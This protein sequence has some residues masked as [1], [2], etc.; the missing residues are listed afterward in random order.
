[1]S[2]SRELQRRRDSESEKEERAEEFMIKGDM[3]NISFQT[4]NSARQLLTKAR[5]TGIVRASDK[6]PRKCEIYQRK[7]RRNRKSDTRKPE[8]WNEI[9]HRT[10]RQHQDMIVNSKYHPLS[11]PGIEFFGTKM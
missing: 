1:M 8:K 7:S 4:T 2:E 3:T 11:V 5:K 6:N 9:S 10:N